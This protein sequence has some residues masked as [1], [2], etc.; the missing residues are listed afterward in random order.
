MIRSISKHSYHF[1]IVRHLI[2]LHLFPPQITRRKIHLYK[3]TSQP[4]LTRHKSK[5]NANSRSS[6]TSQT[7]NNSMNNRRTTRQRTHY[8][9]TINGA[10]SSNRNTA[11]RLDLSRLLPHRYRNKQM[12]IRHP[13]LRCISSISFISYTV[14]LINNITDSL[15][16]TRCQK[17]SHCRHRTHR[18]AVATYPYQNPKFS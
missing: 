11:R 15:S 3:G 18:P 1:S 14:R 9:R 2:S 10:Y 5:G 17:R 16:R 6:P 12:N 7:L 13:T 8:D 4:L